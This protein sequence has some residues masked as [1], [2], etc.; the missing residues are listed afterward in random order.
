MKH[1]GWVALTASLA[2]SSGVAAQS[3]YTLLVFGD[4]GTGEED[5]RVVAGA[6]AEACQQSSCDA[7]LV[8]GDLIYPSGVQ[9]PEDALFQ[10][11]FELP[12]AAVGP[13]PFWMAP[14]N[15]D[16][17]GSVD[18]Q[19]AYA[20]L[21]TS[22]RWRMPAAHYAVEDLPDWLHV[23]SL[24]TELFARKKK[25]PDRTQADQARAALCGKPGWRLLAG[26]HPVY[27]N[28]V[29]GSNAAVGSYLAEVI[30]DCEVQAF[31]AGHDHHQEHLSAALPFEQ[32]I[33]GAAAKL[34][35]VKTVSDPVEGVTQR[36][37]RK[38][39]GFAIATF[40]EGT[41]DVRFFDGTAG[42]ATQIYRCRAT[43]DAPACVPQ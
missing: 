11:H 13:F 5:Q 2:F 14:G 27:S 16:H 33:Q 30:R 26:H 18:A 24:D 23:Y 43:I 17:K 19:I 40:T 4:S 37:A 22:Q 39:L 1:A 28:G 12:Y 6:M 3:D 21:G 34:R 20:H 41:M 25:A 35:R 7:A 9:S 29:H 31:F 32:F 38:A 42:S 10:T 15:H 36:F 8:L